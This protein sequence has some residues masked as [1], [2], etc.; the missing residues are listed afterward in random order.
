MERLR[1]K[2]CGA[3]LGRVI[4]FEAEFGYA[5]AEFGFEFDL[6]TR[7][8]AKILIITAELNWSPNFTLR[9]APSWR[10]RSYPLVE[11]EPDPLDPIMPF[12]SS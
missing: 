12:I 4:R 1:L 7:A 10:R 11:T 5:S 6:T 9:F 8:A 3:V 2:R